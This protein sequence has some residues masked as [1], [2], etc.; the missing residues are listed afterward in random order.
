MF[1]TDRLYDDYEFHQRRYSHRDELDIWVGN[2]I[3]SRPGRYHKLMAQVGDG[4][5]AA[6]RSIKKNT[7]VLQR[8]RFSFP[9][10]GE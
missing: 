3:V 5:I 2:A 8:L 10:R 4:L 1:F 7:A 9:K 6:G